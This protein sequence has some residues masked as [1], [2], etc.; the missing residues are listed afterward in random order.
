MY[1]W[2]GVRNVVCAQNVCHCDLVCENIDL[3][4][5][6]YEQINSYITKRMEGAKKEEN[7]IF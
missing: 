5:R 6:K 7:I 1:E 4:Y 2:M 3:L